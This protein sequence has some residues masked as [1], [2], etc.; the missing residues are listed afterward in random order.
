MENTMIKKFNTALRTSMAAAVVSLTAAPALMAEQS[1]QGLDLLLAEPTSF[2]AISEGAPGQV[3]FAA[4]AGDQLAVQ[5]LIPTHGGDTF[6]E[7]VGTVDDQGVFHGNKMLIGENGRG[8]AAPV[9]MVFHESGWISADVQNDAI[10]SGFMTA[11]MY[12]GY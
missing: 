9:T 8:E 10:G 1:P 4:M 5:F 2:V 12:A 11:E 6:G 3:I 7:I